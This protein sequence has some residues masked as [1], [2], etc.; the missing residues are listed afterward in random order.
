GFRPRVLLLGGDRLLEAIEANP[1]PEAD[2]EPRSLH[3]FFLAEPPPS[4]DLESLAEVAVASERFHLERDVFYLH[5]P[6]GF[7]RSKLAARVER[8]LG[9]A[10]TARNWRTVR[11]LQEMVEEAS[12]RRTA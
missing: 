5:A 1:F 7:G 11:K 9:V 12:R 3:L 2:A 4:P 8:Y 10:A 6:E